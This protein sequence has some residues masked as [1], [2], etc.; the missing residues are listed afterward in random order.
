[1]QDSEKI[2]LDFFPQQS[3]MLFHPANYVMMAIGR[4]WGKT[5]GLAMWMI[6][7]LLEDAKNPGIWVDTRH[8][9][10]DKYV[11]RY[12]KMIIGKTWKYFDYNK[13]RKILTFP[14]E[15]YLDFA[16]AEKPQ[17]AEGFGYGYGVLNEA[18][19]ILKK[20]GL[21]DNTLRPMF[22]KHSKLRI[23][24]T[25]K[26]K[27]KF[28]SLYNLG[29]SDDEKYKSFQVPS[30]TSPYCDPQWIEDIKK[31]LPERAFRQEIMGEFIEG[32]GS[33]FR[34][35]EYIVGDYS[36]LDRGENG[37]VYMMGIDLGRTVDY[38]VILVGD[39]ETK[40]VVYAERFRNPSW[41]HIFK[42][43]IDVYERFNKPLS[44]I[45]ATGMGSKIT[46]DLTNANVQVQPV[47]Y[48]SA[49]KINL[50]DNLAVAIENK[51]LTIPKEVEYLQDELVAFEY[52]LSPQKTI[53]YSAPD[54]F[55]DDAVNALALL[56]SGWRDYN[57][58]LSFV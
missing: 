49:I 46:E 57:V 54:G 51:E 34:N 9:N 12:F 22:N 33:V 52:D 10:I 19:I 38:T 28:F 2:N 3:E 32:E 55:H 35:I 48:T 41:A 4:R 50:I 56:N 25:P 30:L 16:S 47:V 5:Y 58:N 31:E 53:R 44:I 1:M 45:D 17:S 26:G 7:M 8:A 13:Q 23:A 39:V 14:N 37:R 21:W 29:L 18:G 6:A 42:R 15:N 11:D 24:G 36:L 40:K 20:E 27:G 43:I